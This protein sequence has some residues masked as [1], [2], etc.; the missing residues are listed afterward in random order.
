[1]MTTVTVERTTN[2][3]AFRASIDNV[4]LEFNAAGKASRRVNNGDHI[5]SWTVVGKGSTFNIKITFPKSTGC[6]SSSAGTKKEIV[7][8]ACPFTT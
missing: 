5:L 3:K 6:G 1:M 2:A 7:S 4:R 8:G